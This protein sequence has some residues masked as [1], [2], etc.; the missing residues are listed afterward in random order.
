MLKNFIF[1]IFIVTFVN[2]NLLQD[3]IDKAPVG[4]ILK[5]PNGVYKGSIIINK[6]ITI[7]GQGDNVIIDG[8]DSG[9]VIIAK[10]SYITLKNL[11]IIN[12]GDRHENLD[13]AI[14]LSDGKQNEISNVLLKIAYS[15]L[16]FKWLLILLY[17]IIR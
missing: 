13:S 17:Q 15:V 7:I 14:K 2:G 4:A 3:T 12:S 9:T 6:P 16:M 8:E 1:S 11:T 10:G 5:L